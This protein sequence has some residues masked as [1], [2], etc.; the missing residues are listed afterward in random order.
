MDEKKEIIFCWVPSHV[1]IKENETE[2]LYTKRSLKENVTEYF[3]SNTDFKKYINDFMKYSWQTRWNA[4]HRNKL[5]AILSQVM[6][7]VTMNVNTRCLI[8]HS[9][10]THFH[11]LNQHLYV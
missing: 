3:V 8:G 2:D 9:R 5:H 1:D 10:L 11:M 4:C 6:S 7:E